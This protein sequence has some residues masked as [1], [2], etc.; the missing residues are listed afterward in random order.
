MD[1]V[2]Y[3]FGWWKG[4]RTFFIRDM[5][6]HKTLIVLINKDKGSGSVHFWDIIESDTLALGLKTNLQFNQE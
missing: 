6:H 2:V 3:H 5:R 1:S 4:F